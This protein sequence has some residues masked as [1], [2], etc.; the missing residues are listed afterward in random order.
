MFSD[1][2]PSM[3]LCERRVSAAR[4]CWDWRVCQEVNPTF[5]AVGISAHIAHGLRDAL[6]CGAA[7][8]R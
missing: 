7:I 1:M 3:H 4:E 2:R 6:E 5:E 8:T